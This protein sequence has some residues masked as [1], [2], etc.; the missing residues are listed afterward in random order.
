MVI[1]TNGKEMKT[2]IVTVLIWVIAT[3]VIALCALFNHL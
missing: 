1:V 2:K 3:C